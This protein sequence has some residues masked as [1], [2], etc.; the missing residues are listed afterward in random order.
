MKKCLVVDDSRVIRK[1]A[2][3]IL[4]ELNFEIEEAEDGA[5]ALEACR[6]NMPD[7]ILLDWTLPNMSG[8]EFLRALRREDGGNKPVVLMCTSENDVAQVTEAVS[9]GVNEYVLKP[10]DRKSIESKLSDAGLLR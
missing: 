3:K 5:G 6:Q 1:V 9:V 7:A 4:E 10:F 8:V 2:R